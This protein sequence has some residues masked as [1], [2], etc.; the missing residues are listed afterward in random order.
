MLIKDL[1]HILLLLNWQNEF[2]GIGN[3]WVKHDIVVVVVIASRILWRWC[4][5]LRL[6]FTQDLFGPGRPRPQYTAKDDLLLLTPPPH[7]CLLSAG[8]II[9]IH[10][11]SNA[12]LRSWC[13]GLKGWLSQQ[14]L[15]VQ[16]GELDFNTQCLYKNLAQWYVCVVPALDMQTQEDVQSLLTS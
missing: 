11:W 7:F 14:V 12:F 10:Q 8:I 1:A 3:F 2:P 4:R 16:A 9:G 15:V 5:M 6:F 13:S